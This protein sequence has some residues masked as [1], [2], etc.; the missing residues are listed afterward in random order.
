M[1]AGERAESGL[2]DEVLGVE[3]RWKIGGAGIPRASTIWEGM[4]NG[5]AP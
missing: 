5:R 3:D 4:W 2:R 1:L